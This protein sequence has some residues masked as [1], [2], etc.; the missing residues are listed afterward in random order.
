MLTTLNADNQTNKWS[1]GVRFV[2]FMKNHVYHSAIKRSPYEAMYD[3]PEKVVL[4]SSIIPQSVLHWV[5]TEEDL[6]KLE[7]SQ[8]NMIMGSHSNLSQEDIPSSLLLQNH[9]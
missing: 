1:E 2:Q 8:E 5:N 7:D 3:C 6:E 4:S 9:L